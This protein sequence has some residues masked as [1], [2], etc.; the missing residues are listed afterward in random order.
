MTGRD[1]REHGRAATPLELFFDLVV[2]VAVALAA[3]RLHH[4][5]I[6]GVVLDALISYAMVF[7][8][9]WWAWANFTWFASAYDNDDVAFRVSAFITMA[10]A[11]VLAAGVPSAFDGRDFTLSVI[12]Y[13]IMRVALL[14]QWLRVTRDD[15]EHAAAVRRYVAGVFL[16]QL[17]WIALIVLPNIWPLAWL[18]LVPAE[19]IVPY[20]AQSSVRINF[21]NEHLAERYGLFMIIVLGELVLAASIAIQSILGVDTLTLEL[22]SVVVGGL[23]IGFAMWWMD[24]DRPE[25]HLLDSLTEAQIWNYLHLVIFAAVAAVGAGVVVAIEEAT[26]HAH[27]GWAAVGLFVAV[28]LALYLGG[29]LL[30]YLR[31]PMPSLHRLMLP[32]FMALIL[33]AAFLPMPVLLIGLLLTAEIALKVAFR[34]RGPRPVVTPA[35]L[36]E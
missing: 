19:L 11:L 36:R 15:R 3:E 13:V 29:L 6:D 26:G 31:E 8:G 22:I 24:F 25:E 12:G 30:L 18:V 34:L 20:L 16:V 21:H 9:I 35:P 17:G 32:V 10:G 23:L 28:P 33:V 4:A 27:V 5:L 14:T 2:V 7:F 1:P